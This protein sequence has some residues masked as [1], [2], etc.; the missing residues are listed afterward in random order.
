MFLNMFLP[1]AVSNI[2][3]NMIKRIYQPS[4]N[5]IFNKNQK[6]ISIKLL[7]KYYLNL[8]TVLLDRQLQRID[9]YVAQCKLRSFKT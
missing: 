7:N 4:N 3:Q 2:L 8:L 5:N 6:W 9:K 1:W